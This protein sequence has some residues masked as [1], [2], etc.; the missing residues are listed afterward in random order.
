MPST[1]QQ[2]YDH[3][4]ANEYAPVYFLHGEEA[5]Y[6]DKVSDFVE[7]NALSETEKGFNQTIVYGKDAD[8]ATLLNHARRFPMMSEKQVVIV[9]EAQ[10]VSNLMKEDGVKLLESYLQNPLPST[11]L[12]FNY[13]HKTLDKRTKLAKALEKYAV[14]MESK[15]LYD[16]QVP[17]WIFGYVKEKG[18]TIVDKAALL[19]AQYIGTNLERMAH[20]IDKI[21]INFKEP[22]RIEVGH[23][24]KFVGISKEYNV[25]ELQKAIATQDM[26]MAIKIANYFEANPKS[27]PLLPVITTI[28][29]LFSRLLIVHKEPN[30][31]DNNIASVLGVHRFF[32]GEY[33]IAARNYP[34]SKVIEN[35]GHIR[36]AD[37][38]SK[39][40]GTGTITDGQILKELIYKL[41]S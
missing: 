24:Q 28:F 34:L 31:S 38:A 35:V 9:K 23:I 19:L 11:I 18:F 1:F 40:I 29:N 26:P 32:A 4:K 8:V 25:F 6:I 13:K 7:S 10:E 15:K 37:L 30:K 5:Y 39:S 33:L 14:V 2:I 27:N 17:D 41:M 21:L 12:V 3:L 22:V 20:E 36:Q 16:N